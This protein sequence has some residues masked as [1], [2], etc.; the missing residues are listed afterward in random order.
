MAEGL[1]SKDALEAH[2]KLEVKLQEEMERRMTGESNLQDQIL[3]IS[4][5]LK[6][7]GEDQGNTKKTL[8]LMQ[9][10]LSKIAE[11]MEICNRD[12]PILGEGAVAGNNHFVAPVVPAIK[13]LSD[14]GNS[15]HT[16]SLQVSGTYHHSVPRL[17][18]P[19]FDGSNPRTWLLK[20][21]NYFKIARDIPEQDRV[22]M[23]GL[24][25][26]GKAAQW[27][28]YMCQ[29]YSEP[30]WERFVE[31]VSARFEELKEGKVMAEFHKLSV[32]SSV[33]E[34]IDKFE[35]LRSYLLMFN[36]RNYD[37]RYFVDC[38]IGGLSE[39]SQ[40][41]LAIFNPQTLQ[42]VM[43]M[44]KQQEAALEAIKKSKPILKPNFQTQNPPRKFTPNHPPIR[45]RPL[46]TI[47][48]LYLPY[49]HPKS[50]SPLLRCEPEGRRSYALIVMN[51]LA[52]DINVS[53]TN[54]TCL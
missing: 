42:Q 31:L 13:P 8:E 5:E 27:F 49:C 36:S 18:F 35:E 24:H 17:D 45:Y 4:Q 52:L 46:N 19:R 34:Y 22:T 15:K 16:E 9:F 43:E 30:S 26:E 20:C 11:R 32:T 2:K 39:E 3:S 38:F 21:Q 29:N 33:D 7:V 50:Y 10:Q 28:G 37:E 47:P 12:K 54:Y 40:K 53:R 1:R 6:N 48:T 14:F 51:N 41:F 44:A 23:A 25:F